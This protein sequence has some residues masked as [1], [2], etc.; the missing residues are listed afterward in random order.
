MNL[1]FICL[2]AFSAVMLLLGLLAALI[3]GIT[4]IFPEN[5]AEDEA[6]YAKAISAA[7]SKMIPGA[8]VTKVED[9]SESK[10]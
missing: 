9:V 10:S 5:K 2:I 3:H 6:A 4:S 1:L 8:V 7:V